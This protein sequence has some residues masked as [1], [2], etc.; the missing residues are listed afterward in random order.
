MEQTPEAPT[1]PEDVRCA[2]CQSVL[3]EGQ[4]RMTTEEGAVFCRVCFDNLTAQ[5]HRVVEAQGTDINYSMAAVGGLAGGMVGVL[6]WWGF[7]VLTSISFGLVAVV[8]GF[9]VGKGI[10]MLTSEKRSVNLQVLAV[11]IATVSFVYAN[12]L[13]TRSFILDAQPGLTLPWIPNL[14]LLF[15]VT[16]AGVHFMDVVFLAIV[17]YEAWKIPAPTRLAG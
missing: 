9:T 14:T 1:T 17:I 13:V 4:E 11:V 15:D 2:E 7:T 3:S 5:L 10:L 16:Y 12:Y 8:I 6:V